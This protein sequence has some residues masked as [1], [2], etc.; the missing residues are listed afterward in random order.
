L[1]NENSHMKVEKLKLPIY[2]DMVLFLIH[3]RAICN[4]KK[5]YVDIQGNFKFWPSYQYFQSSRPQAPKKPKKI[6]Y[7][8]IDFTSYHSFLRQK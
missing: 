1:K 4:Q 8:K 3:Q 5:Y 7:V 6:K 2:I